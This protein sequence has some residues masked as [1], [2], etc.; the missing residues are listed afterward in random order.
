MEPKPTRYDLKWK[1]FGIPVRVHWAFWLVGL[2][3]GWQ[4]KASPGLL[5]WVGC[6]FISI[7]IHEFGH[8]LTAKYFGA[9]GLRIVLYWLG[10]LAVNEGGLRRKH[11]IIELF[12]G[13]GA[14]FILGG[15]VY[16]I[17]L[18]TEHGLITLPQN[19]Y[20][21]LALYY[22]LYINIWWGL[23]NLLPIFPLDGGQITQEV[24]RARRPIGGAALAFRISF[25]AALLCA[26][27][28]I[29]YE[30]YVSLGGEEASLRLI[31]FF[32]FLAYWNFQL[33]QPHIA[34]AMGGDRDSGPRQPW[35]QDADWWKK[36][37]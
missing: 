3:L 22:L 7:V 37:D 21:H 31:I 20:V 8:A 36:G 25:F 32:A 10:G 19:K 11:R 16:G 5:V 17:V 34:E 15:V 24:V 9:R 23:A 6:L 33:S 4:D 29:G 14:G 35:E 26:A 18:L 30:I 12:C 13:A 28:A 1:L 2:I 27:V